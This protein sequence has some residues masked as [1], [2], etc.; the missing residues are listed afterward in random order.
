MKKKYIYKRFQYSEADDF[1]NWLSSK[2]EK[3]WRFRKFNFGMTFEKC[4]PQKLEYD[5]QVFLKNSELDQLP[6]PDT[7]EFAEYCRTAGYELVDGIRRFVVFEKK[8]PD[9]V[10]IF[11]PEERFREIFLAERHLRFTELISILFILAIY[12]FCI[13]TNPAFFLFVPAMNIVILY[14]ILSGILRLLIL[15][16]LVFD[17]LYIL[18]IYMAVIKFHTSAQNRTFILAN[19]H[20]AFCYNSLYCICSCVF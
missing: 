10:A 18:I 7:E 13:V 2:A 5:V 11:T 6:R 9:A 1:A 12:G 20:L 3:G 17:Y 16:D 14:F 8:T 4:E 15:G 19:W